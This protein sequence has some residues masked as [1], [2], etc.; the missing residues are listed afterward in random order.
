MFRVYITHR[1]KAVYMKKCVLIILDGIGDRA[2][3]E[4]SNRTPL[5][6]AHTPTLD[7]L[8]SL[9]SNGL[10]HAGMPG[11]ALP[12]ENAH[13]AIFGYDEQD[14]PGR[15]A[16]E[17]LGAG[18]DI[19]PG[20]VCVLSHFASLKEKHGTL[21]LE[22][23]KPAAE[24]D[25]AE[26]LIDAVREYRIG[27]V[28]IRFHQT[29][30][31]FGVIVLS[32]DVSPCITDT[33]PMREGG[34]LMEVKPWLTHSGDMQARNCAQAL[35]AYLLWAY[36][37]LCHH[38]VNTHRAEFPINGIVT[39]RAGRLRTVRPFLRRYGMKGLSIASGTVYAGISS[40]LGLDFMNMTDTEDVSFDIAQ[41]LI[42]ARKALDEYDF[43]HVH[44]KT[45]DEAAHTKDPL[46][47]KAVIEALDKGIGI[48]IDP[49]M[50]DPETL[51]V[52]T[53]DHSTP[54]T[55]SLIHSGEPVPLTMCGP[56]VRIDEVTLFDEIH[57]A[58]GALS[59]IRGKELMYTIL[60]Y[61]DRSKL[62]GIMDT[63]EDQPYWPGSYEP[64]SL[65]ERNP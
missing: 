46:A 16:L 65:P 56:G 15:G 17:A 59:L 25:E 52:I 5:Q 18:V 42:C 6:A 14:F 60:D 50:N 64:F 13:F 28:D 21:I 4:L 9:G 57:A 11:Q 36:E 27:G 48:S 45:P 31:L 2:I 29:K 8:C 61:L 32:G 19:S 20:D 34:L 23:D 41:R 35:K 39:Q 47:K 53:A 24:H 54:S 63:D 37:R 12:S 49:I 26:A 30:G 38:R 1:D 33:N 10:F 3:A 22:R 7:R 55:G 62:R 40:Y 43:I 58:S 44:T 51:V